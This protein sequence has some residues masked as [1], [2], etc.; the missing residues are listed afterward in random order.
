M[1]WP[2][3]TDDD[4]A[5]H[6]TGSAPLAADC[7]SMDPAARPSFRRRRL[8]PSAA[9]LPTRLLRVQPGCAAT[10]ERRQ[11]G[12]LQSPAEL[13]REEQ[14]AELGRAVRDPRAVECVAGHVIPSDW[15]HPVHVRADG[16]N[17]RTR[18]V[19]TTRSR[20]NPV[21]GEVPEVVRRHLQLEAVGRLA[22]GRTHHP[23]VV[24]QD[25]ESGMRAERTSS[26]ARRTE[27]R[28]ARSRWS[29]SR[30]EPR[31]RPPSCPEPGGP[32]PRSDRPA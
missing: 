7:P 6:R 3:L 12:P 32:F 15:R 20:N 19:V 25:V 5:A 13:R 14:I 8:F 2:E 11:P 18:A 4:V 27:T 28:S 21:E 29:S 22:I 9:P 10:G 26:A 24:H 16:H 1:Y 31:A 30:D 23:G 17:A